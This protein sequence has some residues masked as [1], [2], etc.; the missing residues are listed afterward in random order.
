MKRRH[1]ETV[2]NGVRRSPLVVDFA[3]FVTC[4]WDDG[5]RAASPIDLILG[6]RIPGCVIHCVSM[7]VSRNQTM[8]VYMECDGTPLTRLLLA[9]GDVGMCCVEIFTFGLTP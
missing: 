9:L 5:L 2:S 6:L 3:C 4:L 8:E 1:E 7:A